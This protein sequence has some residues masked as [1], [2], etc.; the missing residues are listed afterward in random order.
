LLQHFIKN[1]NIYYN[2]YVLD[3]YPSKHLLS[4]RIV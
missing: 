1:G 3:G 4:K 2:Q